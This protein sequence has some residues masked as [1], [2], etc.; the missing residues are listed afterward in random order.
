MKRL[1]YFIAT[2]FIISSCGPS[3]EEKAK[4]EEA[5]RA[6]IEALAQQKADSI[7]KIEFEKQEQQRLAD[8]ERARQEEEARKLAEEEEAARIQADKEAEALLNGCWSEY[9][10]ILDAHTTD[11]F[12]PFAPGWKFDVYSQT[13]KSIRI[14]YTKIT[15]EFTYTYRYENGNIYGTDRLGNTNLWFTFDKDQMILRR[16]NGKILRK[17]R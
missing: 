14:Y 2:A 6:R 8:E 1:I 7:A 17:I 3:K 16:P 13:F 11:G 10:D 15:T 5:E 4:Q 12:E 9:N